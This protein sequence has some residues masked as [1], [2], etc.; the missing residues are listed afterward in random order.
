MYCPNV[1]GNGDPTPENIV[2]LDPSSEDSLKNTKK[3]DE[4]RWIKRN[5]MILLGYDLVSK[6]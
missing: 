2:L 4:N 1:Q 3:V 6:L 5:N